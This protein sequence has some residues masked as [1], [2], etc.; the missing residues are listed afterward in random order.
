MESNMR[1]ITK[2]LR[3]FA[4]FWTVGLLVMVVACAIY[5]VLFVSANAQE[6]LANIIKVLNPANIVTYLKARFWVGDT[7]FFL[8]TFLWALPALAACILAERLERRR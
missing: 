8:V 6:G 2:A 7:I 3:R 5:H 4:T 1:R